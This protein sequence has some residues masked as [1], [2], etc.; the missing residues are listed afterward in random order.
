MACLDLSEERLAELAR[1]IGAELTVLTELKSDGV[2][3]PNIEEA[4]GL[5]ALREDSAGNCLPREALLADALCRDGDC[6][7]VPDVFGE[8]GGSA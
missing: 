1:E 3:A 7:L 5:D 2:Y 4:V 8:G 6:F